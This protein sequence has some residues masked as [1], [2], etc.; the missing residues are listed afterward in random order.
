MSDIDVG[1][2]DLSQV[3]TLASI[4]VLFLAI[5]TSACAV[6]MIYTISL[7][8]QDAFSSGLSYINPAPGLE[9]LATVNGILF[10]VFGSLIGYPISSASGK[11]VYLFALVNHLFKSSN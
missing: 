1:Q 4:W 5:G 3:F 10:M 7:A 2:E 11:T 9:F 6:P 8:Y